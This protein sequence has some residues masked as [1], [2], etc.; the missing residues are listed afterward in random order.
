MNRDGDALRALREMA[1]DMDLLLELNAA[2]KLETQWL[3][4]GIRLQDQEHAA[5]IESFGARVRELIV[6]RDRYK[7][8]AEEKRA[9]RVEL[10]EALGIE[11]LPPTA[12]DE[13]LRRGLEVIGALR[14]QRDMTDAAFRASASREA[15][16]RA[17][18][19]ELEQVVIASLKAA[20]VGYIPTHTAERLPEIIADMTTACREHS[21]EREQAE[22]R[23]AELEAALR[24]AVGMGHDDNPTS[25]WEHGRQTTP[26]S[27]RQF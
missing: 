20:P 23:V 13:S 15:A 19:A 4:Q 22:A 3:A 8:R 16:L 9:L 21:E 7:A 6:E 14:A 24:D 27:P 18:V 25:P 5:A 12:A 1:H 2:L 26:R 11:S 17:R 10:E